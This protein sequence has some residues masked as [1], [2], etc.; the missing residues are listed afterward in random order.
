MVR[1]QVHPPRYGRTPASATAVS[2]PGQIPSRHRG[3]RPGPA[4]GGNAPAGAVLTSAKGL[5]AQSRATRQ[6]APREA[7]VILGAAALV[8]ILMESAE[9]ARIANDITLSDEH[10]RAALDAIETLRGALGTKET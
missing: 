8:E 5:R 6:I 7:E 9:R 10:V 1:S 4:G 2:F 3:G